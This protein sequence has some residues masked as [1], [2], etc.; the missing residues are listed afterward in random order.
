MK[1]KSPADI[2]YDKTNEIY[3]ILAE[4]LKNMRAKAMRDTVKN[5]FKDKWMD[6]A[7]PNPYQVEMCQQKMIN[8]HMGFFYENLINLRESTRYRY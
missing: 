5:C 6:D 8:R 2:S 3:A 4:P 1:G 7:V